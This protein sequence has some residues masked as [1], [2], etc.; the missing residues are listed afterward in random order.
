M[1]KWHSIPFNYEPNDLEDLPIEYRVKGYE[2]RDMR[3]RRE[4]LSAF[5]KML[6]FAYYDNIIIRCVSAYRSISYQ[7]KLYKRATLECGVEQADTAKPGY[8]EHHL[9]TAVDLS[10]DEVDYDLVQSFSETKAY[11]WIVKKANIYG[12]YISYTED[13]YKLK[14]YIW[15][16]WHLR[17][18]GGL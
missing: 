9:G 14:G 13:N 12:F 5:V 11:K 4:A 2:N 3:L 7:E 10:C 1:D 8:S 16:P 15:E 6:N 18:M 17:Y